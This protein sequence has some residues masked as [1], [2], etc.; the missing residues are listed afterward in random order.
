MIDDTSDDFEPDL[1]AATREPSLRSIVF[2]YYAQHLPDAEAQRLTTAYIA[3]HR[4]RTDPDAAGVEKAL[5]LCVEF[6]RMFKEDGAALLGEGIHTGLRKGTDADDAAFIWRAIDM[7]R[8]TAWRDATTFAH[9]PFFS[10]W[11]GE[12]ALSAGEA[13]LATHGGTGAQAGEGVPAGCV[14]IRSQPDPDCG[15][16]EEEW[17]TPWGHLFMHLNVDTPTDVALDPD[18]E[19]EQIET[20]LIVSSVQAGR[21]AAFAW[22]SIAALQPRTVLATP[23]ANPTAADDGRAAAELLAELAELDNLILFNGVEPNGWWEIRR[24]SVKGEIIGRGAT[25]L[26]ALRVALQ[27]R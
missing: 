23:C 19:S 8:S 25:P 10:M 7:S 18:G 5:R 20:T 24:G 21:S 1:G 4:Q 26:D 17:D 12:K 6:I 16:P 14:L 2:N 13:A 27:P 15:C 22:A 9:D 11:G 3:A